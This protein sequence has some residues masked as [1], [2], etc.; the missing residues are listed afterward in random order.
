MIC[1]ERTCLTSAGQLQTG[2]KINKTKS[3]SL[4]IVFIIGYKIINEFVNWHETNELRVKFNTNIEALKISYVS[5]SIK[6]DQPFDIVN[7]LQ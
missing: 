7:E 2:R 5:G 6:N 3:S 1:F 4:L